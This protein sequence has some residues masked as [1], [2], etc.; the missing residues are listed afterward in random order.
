MRAMSARRW[1]CCR[2]YR[3]EAAFR[4]TKMAIVY[5]ALGNRTEAFACLEEAYSKWD[6]YLWVRLNVDPRLDPLRSHPRFTA[7]LDTIRLH[8]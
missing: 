3:T 7:L 5:T 8:H 6:G 4:L 1:K 2:R